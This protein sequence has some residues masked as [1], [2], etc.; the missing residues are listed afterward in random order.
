MS[1]DRRIAF[2]LT[3]MGV[4]G[5][6]LW[7]LEGVL[8]PF[9]LGLA[10]AY[11]LDPI[12]DRLEG[13]GLPR[14]LATSIIL[15]SFFLVVVVIILL[16]IPVLQTQLVDF[17]ARVPK[18][19]AALQGYAAPLIERLKAQL[20]P[21]MV[22]KLQAAAESHSGAAVN[23][24]GNALK[25]L[26]SSGLAIFDVLALL[27]ITPLVAFY[28]LRDFDRIVERVD[29]LLPRE[30]APAVREQVLAI[31]T[32]LAGFLRGQATVC[33]LLGAFYGIG[34]TIVGLD[35]GLLIGLGTGLISF[36][37]FFGM[38]IGLIAGLGMAIVQFDGWGPVVTVAAIFVAGQVIEGN[39]LTPKMVGERV[40]LH[41]V[42]VIFGLMAG[43]AL[44]GFAGV[45]L[46]VPLAAIVGV[47]VRFSIARYRA[48]LYYDGASDRDA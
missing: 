16:L 41:P 12:A 39:F 38:L 14:W 22:E 29:D 40:G 45:L 9:I 1:A 33:L 28:M 10:I 46:A 5:V 30:S 44:F 48:S 36:V 13:W 20:T 43:G 18:Y 3:I 11:F 4:V 21:D 35:F 32:I 37:P 8:T 23:W 42:W 26:W 15:G 2:W 31:D 47:L 6:L 24:L 34:L 25:R 17:S 19:A 27:F 7:L